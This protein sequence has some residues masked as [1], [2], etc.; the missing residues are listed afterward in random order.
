MPNVT[1]KLDRLKLRKNIKR[2]S[3]F[4]KESPSSRGRLWMTSR[5]I[6][7]FWPLPHILSFLVIRL[8][9]SRRK[10]PDL[11]LKSHYVS[12]GRPQ[13]RDRWIC[14]LLCLEYS[15]SCCSIIW[16]ATLRFGLSTSGCCCSSCW[17][18]SAA[19]SAC[20]LG[21]LIPVILL[22]SRTIRL[23]SC[24]SGN[25]LDD[26]CWLT[27]FESGC[28]APT[29]SSKPALIFARCCSSQE[30]FVSSFWSVSAR[31]ICLLTF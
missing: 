12:Y 20:W 23:N 8:A 7:Q 3:S 2:K 19:T 30:L 28:S 31:I 4:L 25:R 17:D 10:I 1:R 5:N 16:D 18:G 21:R 9:Y 24:E 13:R 11:S 22:A 6:G 14:Y 15:V 29:S 27:G 26:V